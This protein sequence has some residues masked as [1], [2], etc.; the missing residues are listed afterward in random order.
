[1]VLIVTIAFFLIAYTGSIIGSPLVLRTP[2]ANST[3][4]QISPPTAAGNVQH[5]GVNIAGFD[6]GYQA[7]PQQRNYFCLLMYS[8]CDIDGTC[9][10]SK[11]Y[12]PLG[13]SYGLPDGPGQMKHF[14]AEGLNTFRLPVGWQYLTNSVLGGTLDSTNFNNYN[15]LV[16]AC[17]NTGASCIV[18]IH[19]YAR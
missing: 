1:M 10:P 3:C 7:P 6:F 13:P 9:V 8:R 15:T 11:A 2:A 5:A 17:L 14:A 12:P 18:D 16:Q 4:P 19:N